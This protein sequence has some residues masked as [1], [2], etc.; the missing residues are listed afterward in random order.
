MHFTSWL[1]TEEL[2]ESRINIKLISMALLNIIYHYF[3]IFK[4]YLNVNTYKPHISFHCHYHTSPLIRESPSTA[5]NILVF[6][7]LLN[8][9][10]PR[11]RDCL[12][13]I[14]Q[15]HLRISSVPLS[16]TLRFA[17]V[18]RLRYTKIIICRWGTHS[19]LWWAAWGSS[20]KKHPLKDWTITKDNQH[21]IT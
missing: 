1:W 14:C 12:T 20:S 6:I 5:R 7:P 9:S 3:L 16:P 19:R 10:F 8:S 18:S 4:Y 11:H 17:S 2:S 13:R 21:R 15:L